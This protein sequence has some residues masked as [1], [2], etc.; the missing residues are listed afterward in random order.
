MAGYAEF[1]PPGAVIGGGLYAPN[2]RGCIGYDSS[3]DSAV[4]S[5]HEDEHATRTA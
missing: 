3:A 1:S 2:H 5:P 4:L